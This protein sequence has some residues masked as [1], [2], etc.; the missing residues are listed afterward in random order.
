MQKDK[1]LRIWQIGLFSCIFLF[2]LNLCRTTTLHF[3]GAMNN[4]V[5][6]N[7]AIGNGYATSYDE[8]I[9]FDHVIQTGAPVLFPVALLNVLLGVNYKHMQFVIIGYLFVFLLLVY[10]YIKKYADEKLAFVGII[11]LLCCPHVT[12]NAYAGYGEICMAVWMLLSLFA[13]MKG[14]DGQKARYFVLTGVLVGLGYLTKTVFLICAPAYAIL[15]LENMIST[16][17]IKQWIINCGEVIAG[18]IIPVGSFEVYKWNSL[19]TEEYIKWWT[20]QGKSIIWQTGVTQIASTTSA[21]TGGGFIDKLTIGLNAYSEFYSMPVLVVLI[22]YLIPILYICLGYAKKTKVPS[23]LKWL[24]IVSEIYFV[25]FVAIMPSKKLWARRVIVGH[26]FLVMVLCIIS[27]IVIKYACEKQ[28]RN[29]LNNKVAQ[30]IAIA[31]VGVALMPSISDSREMITEYSE[32]EIDI[33]RLNEYVET[34]PQDAD[35]Y[36]YGWWRNSHVITENGV[37]MYDITETYVIPEESYLIIQFPQLDG[38]PDSME[39][40]TTKTGAQ[41][42]FQTETCYV[43]KLN[44]MSLEW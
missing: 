1:L 20:S 30:G 14:V 31:C 23:S 39:F 15:V 9:E 21:Q 27:Y 12:E 10:A 19:G 18:M 29:W 7:L 3:D 8:L 11:A 28:K 35:Y 42:L 41:L 26:C 33:F 43:Y 17:K 44:P 13:F 16:K 38:E 34:L 32:A 36:A 37:S 2:L 22:L 6:Y 25:W 24:I 4:E 40:I 5:A